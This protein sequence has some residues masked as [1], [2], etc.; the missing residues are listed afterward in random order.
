MNDRP[1]LAETTTPEGRR[2]A[3]FEDTWLVH[4]LDPWVGHPEL[5]HHLG[6]V[7]AAVAEP[8]YR[9]PDARPRRERFFRR[10]AG[11]SEWLMVVVDFEREPPRIVTAFGYGHG[12]APDGVKP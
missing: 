7:L 9:E 3:L 6:G 1:I 12:R 10:H 4:V 2:V 5:Q 11:P 8:D